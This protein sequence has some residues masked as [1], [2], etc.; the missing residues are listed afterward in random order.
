MPFFEFSQNNS[1]GRW[2]INENLCQEVYIEAKDFR[3]A[4][5]IAESKGIYFN[6]VDDGIDCPCFG[7][8]WSTVDESDSIEFPN[9]DW[10]IVTASIEEY[11]R[12]SL[13]YG[14]VFTTPYARIFYK[15]GEVVE[16]HIPR[17]LQ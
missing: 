9:T 16:I 3:E 6:G 12:E 15:S 13:K 1:F 14:F 10:G 8:R 7:N 11:V 17:I 5:D 4:N 2:D